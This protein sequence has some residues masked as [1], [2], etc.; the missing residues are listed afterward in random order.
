MQRMN[1]SV[2]NAAGP[3][4]QGGSGRGGQG[5]ASLKDMSAPAVAAQVAGAPKIED[6]FEFGGQTGQKSNFDQLNGSFKDRLVNAAKAYIE[7]GG[8]KIKL[9]SA[10][11]GQED[12]ERL[13]NTWI[14]AG[15]NLKT[16]PTAAGITTPALPVS[17]G[18]RLN[19]HGAG[20]A[21]D[22]GDQATDINNKIKLKDFGL[23]WGGLFT[24]P[25]K[26]HIQMA[27]FT[28][29]TDQAAP[30][31]DSK[32]SALSAE[33]T[34]SLIN[35]IKGLESFS[36]K[37]FKDHK[38]YSI[39]YGTKA[40]SPEEGPISESEATSR[41]MSSLAGA[42]KYVASFGSKFG[43]K[44]GQPQ[45]DALSSFA[46]NGGNGFI[47]QV[48]GGGKRTNAEILAKI[49]EYNQ[50]S[51]KESSGLVRRRATE[52]GMFGQNLS[53]ANGGIV[54]GPSSGYPATLHGN[55]IITPLSP[56]SILE[57]LGKTPV[58]TEIAG[59]SSSSTSNTIKEIYSMNTE[60][61][62]M[63]AGK[64]DDMIDK[65]DRGNT[66]SDKLVKAMA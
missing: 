60:I 50:A 8:K 46:Y 5:G 51:G 6:L 23:T 15:G 63:L 48:T 42:T 21:I 64:L 57:Q 37:A 17:M 40:N 53:A 32:Q 43:Y 54:N 30:T 58:T 34:G 1:L 28:P 35:M 33:P 55:E 26:V 9:A 52:A 27:N 38:Q 22:A 3:A 56:N 59:S 44:W 4:V 7:A 66:Y 10:F 13:Y 41:L 36:P 39:G 31:T 62:E 20:N 61:M 16:K 19:A 47:D 45:L 65:L 49:P 18:G 24:N 2:P 14:K 12:Q 25:D 11:R 29:G